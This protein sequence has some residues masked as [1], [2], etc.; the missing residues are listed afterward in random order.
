MYWIYYAILTDEY[1]LL[2]AAEMQFLQLMRVS[3]VLPTA[4][5]HH[6]RAENVAF[7]V[8]RPGDTKSMWI[9]PAR[10]HLYVLSDLR[11][12]DIVIPSAKNDADGEGY[13]YNHKV[14]SL[15]TSVSVCLATD[16]FLLDPDPFLSYEVK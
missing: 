5:N 7:E 10:A 13:K 3:E 6:V 11:S 1:A 2:L 8:Q 16:M 15:S 14:M 9:L 12:V 4:D